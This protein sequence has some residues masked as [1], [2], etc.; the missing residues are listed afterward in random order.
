METLLVSS[1][2]T[3]A[4]IGPLAGMSLDQLIKQLPARRRIGVAAY[5]AYM[6][7]ADLGSGVLL[8]GL[9]G[10]GSALAAITAWLFAFG[11]A[12]PA[13]AQLPL[14]ASALLAVLHSGTTAVAAPIAFSLR[15]IAP[16]DKP[17]LTSALD[18]FARWHAARA[19]L[20]VLQFG[21]A[22]WALI[23]LI[24]AAS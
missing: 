17:T 24:Q 23:T 7:S 1:I 18:R 20:Q 6:R 10:L 4:L 22:V 8:Y 19:L 14:A 16:T 15:R 9:F 21:A 3:V 2:A 11:L 12:L 13:A 5:A